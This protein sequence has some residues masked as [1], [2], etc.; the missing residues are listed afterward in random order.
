MINKDDW[1][2]TDSL[3][4]EFLEGL[5]NDKYKVVFIKQENI[6]SHGM[7]VVRKILFDKDT[8]AVIGV[9]KIFNI[10]EEANE[11]TLFFNENIITIDNSSYKFRDFNFLRDS[12]EIMEYNMDTNEI[13]YKPDYYYSRELSSIIIKGYNIA[14]SML[15]YSHS[16]K[17]DDEGRI[18]SKGFIFP[19]QI[20]DY[21]FTHNK[22]YFKY[23][24]EYIHVL[25]K[26]FSLRNLETSS[27]ELKN[28][29]TTH[30]SYSIVFSF[31]A[32]N[33]SEMLEIELGIDG[34]EK[35]YDLFVINSP[36][37]NKQNLTSDSLDMMKR[38]L[39]NILEGTANKENF[40][41]VYHSCDMPSH[42]IAS[43]YFVNNMFSDIRRCVINIVIENNPWFSSICQHRE[44]VTIY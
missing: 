16:S 13:C 40:V 44:K 6:F 5:K 19:F 32:P 22:E 20:F 27:D 25:E 14:D 12:S 15:P 3:T 26:I 7:N 23:L 38:F 9:E 24:L 10:L 35:V 1:Y 42:D 43:M 28:A 2:F 17:C 31:I 8:V 39:I 30:Y 33:I 29:L 18:W 36:I 11:C 21:F 4:L 37:H 34:L 41:K